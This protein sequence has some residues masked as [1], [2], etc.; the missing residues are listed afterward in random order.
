[1]IDGLDAMLENGPWFIQNNPI[2]LKKWHPDENLLKEDGSSS[3]AR[4]MVELQIDVELKDT[5]VVA[6]P[7]ITYKGHYTCNVHVE[8]EGSLLG[9]YL[10]SNSSPFDV[11]NLIDNDVKFCT[12]DGTTN[13]VNNEATSSGSSF[14]NIDNDGEFASNTLIG[15]KINKIE[16]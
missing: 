10:V 1:S 15:E 3:Y 8:Y 11:L 5:I 6:M 16:R 7:K 4:V 12:N 14:M 2:I 9:V 13:L